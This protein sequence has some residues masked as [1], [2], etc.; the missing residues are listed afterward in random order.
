MLMTYQE[1][2]AA[3]VEHYHRFVSGWK[4]RPCSACNGSG[5]YDHNGSPPCGS[6]EGTGKGRYNPAAGSYSSAATPSAKGI[7][8]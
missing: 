6:C 3:R 4:M 1:R 5:H 2:K 7:Q 8:P